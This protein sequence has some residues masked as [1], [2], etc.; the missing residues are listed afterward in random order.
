MTPR[1]GLK[2]GVD[3][4]DLTELVPSGVPETSQ[5]ATKPA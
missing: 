1:L 4:N 2:N 3:T 5:P